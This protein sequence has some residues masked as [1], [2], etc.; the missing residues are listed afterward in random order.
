MLAD[1][2]YLSGTIVLVVLQYKSTYRGANNVIMSH[3]LYLNEKL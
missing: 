2:H 3:S 1:E